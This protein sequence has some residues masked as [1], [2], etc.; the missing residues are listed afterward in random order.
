MI[1]DRRRVRIP[2]SLANVGRQ[3]LDLLFP[4]TCRFCDQSVGSGV[5]FCPPCLRELS[6]SSARMLG[7]CSRCGRPGGGQRSNESPFADS[8]CGKLDVC[9][10]DPAARKRDKKTDRLPSGCPTCRSERFSFDQC[11]AMW[12]YD[13]IVKDAV[14]AS[15]YGSRISLTDA[16]G[17]RLADQ[18]HRSLVNEQEPEDRSFPDVVTCVSESFAAPSSERNW[19]LK[20]PSANRR[21]AAS[22]RSFPTC[23]PQPIGHNA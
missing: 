14:V 12:C 3:S 11:L 18:I 5:D 1:P 6:T 23:F 16:L 8:S 10:G 21:Q 22:F 13:G 20:C 4:S 17:R 15:K 2:E 9:S 7:A 19:G